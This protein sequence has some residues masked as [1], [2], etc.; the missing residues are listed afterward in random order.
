MKLK[1]NQKKKKP[2]Q[3]HQKQNM[4]NQAPYR[5]YFEI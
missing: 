5:F 3:K 2:T 4:G 1:K